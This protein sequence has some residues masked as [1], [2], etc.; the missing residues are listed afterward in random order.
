[1]RARLAVRLYEWLA[2]KLIVRSARVR[3]HRSG[4]GDAHEL[5]HLWAAINAG[6][7][8]GCEDGAKCHLDRL[9]LPTYPEVWT[10]TPSETQADPYLVSLIERAGYP[11][12]SGWTA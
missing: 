8:D 2:G 7:S 9:T 12:G 11:D 4:P 10:A 6:N 5:R 3:A 1:V